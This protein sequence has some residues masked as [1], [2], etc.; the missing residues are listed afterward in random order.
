MCLVCGWHQQLNIIVEIIS[1]GNQSLL[2]IRIQIRDW[3]KAGS[4]GKLF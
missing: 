4:N 3:N 2:R 1:S